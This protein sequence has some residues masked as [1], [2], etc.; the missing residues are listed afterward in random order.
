MT[1]WQSHENLMT[2]I[3]H[4]S[5]KRYQ[6]VILNRYINPADRE[7][8]KGRENFCTTRKLSD[9][10]SKMMMSDRYSNVVSLAVWTTLRLNILPCFI[11]SALFATRKL[12][13]KFSRDD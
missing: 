13:R 8:E 10:S 1:Q 4:F 9:V 12:I 5:M 2:L 3:I 6:W 11:P 7:R